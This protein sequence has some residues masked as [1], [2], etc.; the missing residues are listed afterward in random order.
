MAQI[1][2]KAPWHIWV[3][4]V[5]S[6]LWNSGGALDYTMTQTRNEAYMA[7][8][9]PQQLD[10][11][12]TLPVWFDAFWAVGVWGAFIGSL[13]ILL[14]SRFAYPAFILSLIGLAGSTV[15]TATADIPDSM[16]T[17]GMWAFTAVI[18]ISIVLLI[19]YSRAMRAKRVLR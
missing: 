11:F 17:P 5:L 1:S 3:I 7:A 2:V 13:L 9:T 18:W 16:N 14:R 4:G 6:T 10:Y 8:F 19:W 12:Y 15:H